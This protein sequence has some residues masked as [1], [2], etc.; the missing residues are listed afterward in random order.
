MLDALVRQ[1]APLVPF[2]DTED[3]WH[4]PNMATWH[5]AWAFALEAE[6]STKNLKLPEAIGAQVFWFELGHWPCSLT[7]QSG[8]NSKNGY[9]IY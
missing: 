6:Y 2:D 7:S 5:A 1:I 8:L 4:P 3:A 9:I